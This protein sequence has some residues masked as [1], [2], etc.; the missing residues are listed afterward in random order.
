MPALRTDWLPEASSSL[1][2]LQIRPDDGGTLQPRH[3]WHLRVN[4][5][6]AEILAQLQLFLRAQILVAEEDHTP[7]RNEQRK[8]IALLASEV[9]ELQADNLRANVSC[10]VFHFFGGGEQ[11]SFLGISA[12]AGVDVFAVFVADG[13]DVLEVKW[14]R[15]AVLPAWS[16]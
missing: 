9:L 2:L 14:A 11:S 3:V 10:E 8:L 4:L 13:V 1:G 6:F 15:W 16:V 5:D 7:L 12:R